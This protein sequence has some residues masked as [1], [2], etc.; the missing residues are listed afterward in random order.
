MKMTIHAWVLF[1]ILQSSL[2]V[3]GCKG[4]VNQSPQK[5]VINDTS[6]YSQP[7]KQETS[8]VVSEPSPS[9]SNSF[10]SIELI[11][12]ELPAE[13]LTIGY[14]A[15]SSFSKTQREALLKKNLSTSAGDLH[16]EANDAS[17][18]FLSYRRKWEEEDWLT[19]ITYFRMS[20]G[21]KL[22]GINHIFTGKVQYSA[23]IFFL[24]EF[25]GDWLQR[26]RG[27]VP[28]YSI[29]ALTGNDEDQKNESIWLKAA[30][31]VLHDA[32]PKTP[33]L[34]F[35]LPQKGT[36]LTV[37]PGKVLDSTLPEIIGNREVTFELPFQDGIFAAPGGILDKYLALEH[38]AFSVIER[39]GHQKPFFALEKDSPL[40]RKRMVRENQSHL[41]TLLLGSHPQVV[42]GPNV[43][44]IAWFENQNLVGVYGDC[45]MGC[46]P[47]LRLLQW[48]DDRFIDK[49]KAL[50]RLPDQAYLDD[51]YKQLPSG[52]V[53]TSGID[54][55]YVRIQ[56]NP[57]TEQVRAILEPEI[58]T[59]EEDLLLG[60]YQWREEKFVLIR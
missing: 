12:L 42:V 1:W 33:F 36:K 29:S 35:S 53:A 46:G 56:F 37:H 31:V 49:T 52:K 58:A 23:R 30:P 6:V 34:L 51:L 14:P 15:G 38:T 11:F 10:S 26:E 13:Y 7:S 47:G 16:L 48:E 43:I 5:A 19:Q 27:V 40:N 57:E 8:S 39:K 25:E 4:E 44:E 45:G 22:V 18:A 9:E 59:G 50:I 20:D 17:N 60:T 55:S 21:S 54:V 41:G 24:E 28:Q 2:L 3:T 32:W